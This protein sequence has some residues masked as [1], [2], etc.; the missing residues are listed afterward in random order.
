MLKF[1][2][3]SDFA[4]RGLIMAVLSGVDFIPRVFGIKHVLGAKEEAATQK[5]LSQILS[6]LLAVVVSVL[7][8][9]L[10]PLHVRWDGLWLAICRSVAHCKCGIQTA[11]LTLDIYANLQDLFLRCNCHIFAVLNIDALLKSRKWPLVGTVDIERFQAQV[12]NQVPSRR[13]IYRCWLLDR[14]VSMSH[15]SL[16][17]DTASVLC[18]MWRCR[19]PHRS[20]TTKTHIGVW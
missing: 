11:I 3:I 10:G 9:L 14:L 20:Q 17:K 16:K 19:L 12:V 5:W 13:L 4:V 18:L 15:L 6:T 1:F 2:V 8:L 7:I